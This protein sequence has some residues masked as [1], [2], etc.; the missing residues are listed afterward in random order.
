MP[1]PSEPVEKPEYLTTEQWNSL[2]LA[3][4][5]GVATGTER[6]GM[7]WASDEGVPWASDLGVTALS[8]VRTRLDELWARRDASDG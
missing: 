1:P 4:L 7:P 2:A 8:A 6:A 5:H 3:I